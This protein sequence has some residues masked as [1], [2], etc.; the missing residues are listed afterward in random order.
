[1][2]TLKSKSLGLDYYNQSMLNGQ[3]LTHSGM[4]SEVDVLVISWFSGHGADF[5]IGLL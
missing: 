4:A 1:M 3:L 2:Y 5:K